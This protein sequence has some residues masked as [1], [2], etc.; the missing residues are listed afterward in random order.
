M[1]E[2]IGLAEAPALLKTWNAVPGV[3]VATADVPLPTNKLN[4]VK[5]AAPVPPLAT[6]KIA[7]TFPP[8]KLMGLAVICCPDIVK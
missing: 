5:L 4:A 6:G 2:K 8:L 3:I 7:V 1:S